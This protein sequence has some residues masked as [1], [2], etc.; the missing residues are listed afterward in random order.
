L[1]RLE[2]K[3]LLETERLVL[4]ALELTDSNNTTISR[5]TYWQGRDDASYQRLNELPR[6]A[7]TL[8]ARTRNGPDERV[9]TA[10][11]VNEGRTPALALKITAVDDKGVRVLPALYSDNYV[12]L[13]PGEKRQIDVRLPVSFTN[14]PHLAVRGWNIEP[15]NV[16]AS[17]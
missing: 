15:G 1:P 13:L 11:L 14:T 6:Q 16:P 5:N 7:V 10:D 9:I 3:P 12:T 4:V 2:L 8:H 17:P